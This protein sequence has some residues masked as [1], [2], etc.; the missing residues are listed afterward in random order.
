[1]RMS[2]SNTVSQ[3]VEVDK[4]ELDNVIHA[5]ETAQAICCKNYFGTELQAVVDT[6]RETLM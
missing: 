3:T 2:S 4:S 6:L 1:M 5:L